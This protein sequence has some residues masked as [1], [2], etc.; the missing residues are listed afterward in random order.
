M[1]KA[2][3]AKKQKI[4]AIKYLT[5]IGCACYDTDDS[6][7]KAL[8][9]ASDDCTEEVRLATLAAVKEA[10]EKQCCKNCG[11]SC[12]CKEALVMRLAEMAYERDET[13]C[14]LEPSKRVREAAVEAL[15]VCCPDSGPV[16]EAEEVPPPEERETIP[17]EDE[18]RETGDGEDARDAELPEQDLDSVDDDTT[19]VNSQRSLPAVQGV[20]MELDREL[21]IA[22]VHFQD[23]QTQFP[24]GAKLMAVVEREGQHY[25]LGPLTVYNSFVGS[26][27]VT[28]S[29]ELA[30]D[31]IQRGTPIVSTIR[32]AEKQRS[33]RPSSHVAPAVPLI[34]EGQA[35]SSRRTHG[36]HKQPSDKQRAPLITA[37]SPIV[38]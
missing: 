26:A 37:P 28:A 19:A 33:I 31:D 29:D 14:Y 4:K 36:K 7:T 5:S 27:H 18:I 35:R 6:I 11:S 3:D 21:R 25:W 38:R 24:V 15:N 1:K 8:I 23:S 22:H 30:W 12:C 16:Q 13:G 17:T 2:E 20:V 34:S 9:S 10:A 32:V